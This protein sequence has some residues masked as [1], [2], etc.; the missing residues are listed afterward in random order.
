MSEEQMNQNE[1]SEAQCKLTLLFILV[2]VS[3]LLS[4][5]SLV[6]SVMN[7]RGIT[8]GGDNNAQQQQ[9]DDK[10]AISKKY[11][12]GRSLDKALKTGKPIIVFFYTDWC[13]FCQ[14]FAPTFDKITKGI[15]IKKEFAIAYVNCEDEAN[16]KHMEEYGI[17]GFP[18]VYVI[19]TDGTRKQLDNGT[20]FVDKAEEIVTK[21]ALAVIGK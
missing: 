14:R 21:D 11:D 10:N 8:I 3:L 9:S 15:S 20:F 6:L 13:G 19:K 1:K 7:Y 17:Q 2:V 18:T 4:V 16:R 5:S 12:R